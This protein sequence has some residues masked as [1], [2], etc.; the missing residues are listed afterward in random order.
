MENMKSRK[1]KWW[2]QEGNV[3]KLKHNSAQKNGKCLEKRKDKRDSN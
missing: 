3:W 1:E 2:E